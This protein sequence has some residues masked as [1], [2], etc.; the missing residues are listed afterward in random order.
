MKLLNLKN[1]NNLAT[2]YFRDQKVFKVESLLWD[3]TLKLG[4]PEP[5]D[6]DSDIPEMMVPSFPVT[7]SLIGIKN[8]SENILRSIKCYITVS[9]NGFANTNMLMAAI[10]DITN[11]IQNISIYA[12]MS[13]VKANEGSYFIDLDSPVDLSNWLQY[14]IS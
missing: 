11:L 1:G 12:H 5:F 10:S 7:I 4:E 2:F 9:E 14:R 3:N 8:N 6:I 13:G